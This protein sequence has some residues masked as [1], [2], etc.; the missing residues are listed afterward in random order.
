MT[1]TTASLIG[2]ALGVLSAKVLYQHFYSDEE[3]EVPALIYVAGGTVGYLAGR[4]VGGSSSSF[5]ARAN[6]KHGDGRVGTGALKLLGQINPNKLYREEVT[7]H[8]KIGLVYPNEKTVG[9]F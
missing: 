9:T 2:A 4:H 8:V 1:Q 3:E 5:L 7:P 6:S